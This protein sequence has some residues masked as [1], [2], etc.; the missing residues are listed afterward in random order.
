MVADDDEQF[1]VVAEFAGEF[2][3]YLLD[4]LN[5]GDVDFVVGQRGAVGEHGEDESLVGGIPAVD[6][7]GGVGFGKAELLGA[8][9]SRF[10]RDSFM[11]HGGEDVVRC[12]VDDADD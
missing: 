6:V 9:Q 11:F 12:A 2:E 1:D 4:A 8:G 3:V 7:K 5:A 10:E